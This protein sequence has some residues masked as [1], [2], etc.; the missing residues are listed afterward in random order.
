MSM[1]EWLRQNVT[2]LSTIDP[3]GA[4]D[5]LEPLR[6]IVGDAR[7][8]ALGEG[9]HFVEEV[10]TVRR[11]LLRF[12]HERLG[13]GIV[14]AEFDLG[15]GEELA[16]WLADPSDPRPLREVSRGAADWGM[17]STAHWLRSWT[18]AGGDAV[19]FV[20]LDAP[21]GGAAFAAMLA[22]LARF[23]REMD[24][25]SVPTL[26]RIEPIAAMFAG[27]SVARSAEEW[28][29]LGEAKQ[30]AL[31][32][33]LAR[34]HQ[35]VRMLD[36]LLVKRSERR[37]VDGAR[38]RLEALSCADY[39][40]RANEAMHRG[41]DA[42]LDLSVRDRFMADSV[43]AMLE[44]EPEARIALLA[45]NGHV[46]REPVVWG[47][48][49]SAH[50]MGLYLDGALGDRYRV[51]GTTTTG[52]RTSEMTF[53]MSRDVGFA[54]VEAELEPP[55]EGSPEAALVAA[56]LGDRVTLSEVRRA[57]ECGLSFDRVRAQSGYLVGNIAT[58][59]D[60]IVAL[61]RFTV[62]RELGF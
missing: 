57:P 10:W 19:R 48:Y 47:D 54:V 7:V 31:T 44:R 32:A 20:G 41:A 60:A 59:Y 22:W 56:G 34:L 46:Q 26:E 58:A 12:L 9:A 49:L 37:R 28:A 62:Q 18:Q 42:L 24:P 50:P 3:D 8:V 25:A 61:P 23:L 53:D 5:D 27:T 4:L 35:R 16:R 40:M 15:E 6:E 11:R 33:G 38:R 39:A 17:S 51:I 36:A 1:S 30:D 2:T 55:Q 14:A 43:L 21:N 52:D 29:L 13:F 45:H